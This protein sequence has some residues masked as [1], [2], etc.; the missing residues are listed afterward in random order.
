MCS[1][2]TPAVSGVIAC[3]FPSIMAHNAVARAITAYF[4]T[5]G[6]VFAV[7]SARDVS[8]RRVLL[9]LAA[10]FIACAKQLQDSMNALDW[11]SFAPV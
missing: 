2:N 11:V 3:V 6:A 10:A 9:M 4:L 5:L 7:F 1:I 8:N